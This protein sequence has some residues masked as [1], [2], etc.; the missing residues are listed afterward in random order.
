MAFIVKEKL[1]SKKWFIFF[2]SL[3]FTPI[4]ICNT[5]NLI[6]MNF[7]GF[8]IFNLIMTFF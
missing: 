8:A 2:C 5:Q 3:L 7:K 6:I 4:S 1:F